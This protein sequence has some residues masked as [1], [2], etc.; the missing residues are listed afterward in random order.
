VIIG[1]E[2]ALGGGGGGGGGGVWGVW[3]VREECMGW[4]MCEGGAVV[5][6]VQ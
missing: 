5:G 6:Y 1:S 4:A 3:G 2:G